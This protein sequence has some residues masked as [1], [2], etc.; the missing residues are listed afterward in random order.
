MRISNQ[1][2]ITLTPNY[3][4]SIRGD[5]KPEET[6]KEYLIEPLFNPLVANQPVRITDKNNNR[7]D[8]DDLVN[9]VLACSG[10]QV[11]PDAEK[12]MRTIF[13]KTLTHFDPNTHL[14]IQETYAIQAG[15]K[16]KLPFPSPTTVYTPATDVIPAS[17]EFMAGTCTFEH[18]F[19]SLAY[20]ARPDTLGFYFIN[21]IAFNDFKE[22]L[23][24]EINQISS[25]LPA[26]TNQLFSEF[27]QLNLDGLTESL[28]LRAEDG[29]S[30]QEFSFARTL[31]AYMMLYV[32]NISP[33]L[34]GIIPFR[35][36]ELFA[37]RTI[38]MVNIEKHAHASAKQVAEE[39]N[40]INTSLGMKVKIVDSNKLSKL[41]GTTRA[42]QKMRANAANA[43]AQKGMGV[44]RAA[45]AKFK[46]TAPTTV[47]MTRIVKKVIDRMAFTN[48]SD[49]TY[50][51]SKMTFARSNRR[52]PDDFNKQGKSVSTKY[53]PDIHLYIDTSGSISERNYQDAVKA[54]IQMARKLNINLY[55][56]SFS[57]V[58]SQEAK[59]D[60][61]YKSPS[62]IY[63]DF[64][65]IPK[66][67]GGTDYIQIW[68]Y[69]NARPERRRR[70]NLVMTD[71]EWTPPNK[72]FR[73]PKNLYYLP[74]SN[75]DWDSIVYHAQRYSESMK[76]IDPNC[77][78]R[79]LF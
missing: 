14:S 25:G 35:I 74:V 75:M 46:K 16:E 10:E 40:L 63:K 24:D 62:A 32:R 56:N 55:F 66:V 61:K 11:N 79:L 5:F 17:K 53:K 65:R 2:P 64:N 73:H 19:A 72:H 77:R 43:I 60:T 28:I 3:D 45:H 58:L 78:K 52:D 30:N 57:H 33:A 67:S 69:I 34:Y 9:Y 44:Q 18:W 26:E 21:D 22:W 54:V 47:D 1:K 23:R 37:P 70:L 50:K 4:V 59:L 41:T 39:W 51:A 36:D 42:V 15:V 29:D 38:V 76:H 6:L 8:E 7:I 12:V 71:F 13:G 48:K 68:N 49:N 20:Y 27:Y 31:I